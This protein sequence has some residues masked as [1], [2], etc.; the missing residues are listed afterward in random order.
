M[1]PTKNVS[2]KCMAG[3]FSLAF[4]NF[5]K[6]GET[7]KRKG[8]K[9]VVWCE[10]FCWGNRSRVRGVGKWLRRYI[11]KPVLYSPKLMC[12]SLSRACITFVSQL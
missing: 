1:I 3:S 12:A 8:G 7:G 11:Y 5:T 10:P 4:R 9:G 6:I 2:Q